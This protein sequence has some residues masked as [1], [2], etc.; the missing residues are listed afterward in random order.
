MYVKENIAPYVEILSELNHT[1]K[2]GEE[3]W[4]LIKKPGRKKMII[5]LVYRPPSGRVDPFC[6]MNDTLSIIET[7]NNLLQTEM[8]ILGDFN[9]KYT[10]THSAIREQLKTTM[11]SQGL[12]QVIKKATRVTNNSSSLIDLIF[13]NIQ[14]TLVNAVG[15]MNVCISDHMAIFL[16]RKHRDINIKKKVFPVDDMQTIPKRSLRPSQTGR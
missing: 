1:D 16:C 15:V 11:C 2:L 9:V 14:P 5:G 7:T 13:T 12:R 6:R 8:L 3:Y 4:I 10:L